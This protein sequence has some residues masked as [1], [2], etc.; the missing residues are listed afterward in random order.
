MTNEEGNPFAV[1]YHTSWP[2]ALL[3]PL[4]GLNHRPLFAAIVGSLRGNSGRTGAVTSHVADFISFA[5][6]K[7]AVSLILRFSGR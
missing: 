2:A 7:E 1:V 4:V 5:E 6:E 3:I